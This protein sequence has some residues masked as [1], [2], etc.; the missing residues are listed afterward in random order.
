MNERMRQLYQDRGAFIVPRTRLPSPY[1]TRTCES[2]S[3]SIVGA[4]SCGR[5]RRGDW[6]LWLP[7]VPFIL[8]LPL[9]FFPLTV[10]AHTITNTGRIYGQLLNGSKRNAPVAG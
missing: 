9:F 8:I 2:D 1:S 10:S 6:P 7:I 3:A 4:Y 5:P